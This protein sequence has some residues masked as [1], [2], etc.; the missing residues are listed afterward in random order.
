MEVIVRP[1]DIAM[2]RNFLYNSFSLSSLYDSIYKDH[3]GFSKAEWR[4][5]ALMV[6]DK[7][8]ANASI[9][10]ACLAS[11]PN[12]IIGY[13][14][15]SNGVLHFV[16]VKIGYRGQAIGKLLTGDN[17]TRVDRHFMTKLG[18]KILD[19]RFKEIKY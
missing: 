5:E 19:N 6:M 12:T 14:I 2:D 9:Q 4:R 8:Q 16:Y 13:S 1:F 17:Y 18:Q 10:I 3:K 11:S 7:W 15:M